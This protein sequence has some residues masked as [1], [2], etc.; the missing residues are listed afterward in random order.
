MLITINKITKFHND[1]CIFDEAN[2]IIEDNDKMGLVGVNG[3]GKSTLLKIIAGI[4]NYQGETIITKKGLRISYLQQETEFKETD[5]LSVM[6]AHHANAK[7]FEMKAMLNQL[8]LNDLNQKVSTMSGGQKKR[9]ALAVALLQEFDLLILDE[10]TNHLD[11]QMIEYLE[12][13]L[14]KL[15]KALLMVTH[16]RY[17]LERVVN[18]IVEVD[19]TKIYTYDANYSLYLELKEQRMQTLLSQE[20]KRNR[21]LRKEIEW[22]RAGVQ[23]RSTKSKDRLQRFEKMTNIDKVQV[24]KNVNMIQQQTRL[25]NLILEVENISK[26]YGDK[27]LFTDFSYVA[28]RFERIGIL[29][30]NGCGKTTLLA[31]LAKHV[32][33]DSGNIIHGETL[34]IAY[35]KQ[36][37]NDLNDNE[38]VIDYIKSSSHSLKT[39]EGE[40]SASVMCERFLFDKQDQY[41]KIGQ[42]SGG[43]KRRLYLLKILMQA[44]NMLFLDEPT[45]DL[46]IETLAILESYL[47]DFMGNVICVS[48]DRY[49]IDR[50]CDSLLVFEGETIQLKNSSYEMYINEGNDKNSKDASRYEAYKK[51]KEHLKKTQI[52][53]TSKEKN[54]LETLPN[55]IEEQEQLL[56][57]LDEQMNELSIFEEIQQLSQ[58]RNKVDA[59][60]EENNELYFNL[61]EKEEQIQLEKGLN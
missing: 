41:K 1:K 33:I 20:Q 8:Q 11:I 40:L 61:L 21:F 47:D 37:N 16:D 48:H 55:T 57:H 31:A 28:K 22:V 32:E 14:M 10:P 12:K 54:L 52:K 19:A 17:F 15:N 38:R 30:V 45:N 42:L 29:G 44:P 49:F 5:V 43:E 36:E 23:A 59:L 46:D 56:H 24:Q 4:E 53:L 60:L 26:A 39:Q 51:Q 25:G 13:Y 35:Y 50:V 7:E 27:V 18:K 58:E 3:T 34:N 9:L 6:K 2:L